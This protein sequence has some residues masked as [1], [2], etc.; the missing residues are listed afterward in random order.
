MPET[1]HRCSGTVAIRGFQ[2][3]VG[4]L[5]LADYQVASDKRVVGMEEEECG[6]TYR[7]RFFAISAPLYQ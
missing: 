6:A 3:K 4:Q 7:I 1:A 5:I 2:A